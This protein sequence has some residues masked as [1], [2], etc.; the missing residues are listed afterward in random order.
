MQNHWNYFQH[1]CMDKW[2]SRDFSL[3]NLVHTFRSFRFAS[4]QRKMPN[5]KKCHFELIVLYYKGLQQDDGF[6]RVCDWL[7]S[8]WTSCAAPSIGKVEH[9]SWCRIRD[10]CRCGRYMEI[11]GPCW[12]RRKR[13]AN[14]LKRLQKPQVVNPNLVQLTG[15]VEVSSRYFLTGRCHSSNGLTIVKNSL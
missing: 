12:S 1:G 13:V 11:H 10:S 7:R 8:C 14:T 2:R 6:K 15:L 9:V 3:Q 5:N 4:K